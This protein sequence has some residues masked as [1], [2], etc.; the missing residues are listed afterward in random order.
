MGTATEPMGGR[1]L[2][3]AVT[4][5]AAI[6]KRDVDVCHC[7]MCR[8]WTAGP[9]FG[10][11]HQGT[12]AFEGAEHIRVYKSSEW[13]ER[14]FCGVCGTALFWRLSGSDTYSFS[15]GVLDDANDLRLTMQIFIEDK[16]DY[17]DLANDTPK[18]TGAEAM[19]LL[20]GDEA[21]E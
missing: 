4:F 20:S 5:S 15:T 10:L 21:K 19:A 12:V 16:P 11:M 8:R 6:A 17:Y 1:C 7:S 14:A 13:G 2:C 18:L 3:G 9:F